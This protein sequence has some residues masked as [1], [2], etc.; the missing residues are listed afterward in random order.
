MTLEEIFAKISTHMAKGLLI[1]SQMA[2]LYGFLNLRG[3]QRCQ[4]YHY[5][6]ETK[7]YRC[8]QNFFLMYCNKLI[9]EEVVEQPN[10]IP[11]NWYKYPKMEVDIN[12]KRSAVKDLMKKWVEWEKETKVLLELSYKQL[13]ELGEINCAFKIGYFIEDVSKELADAQEQQISLE[14]IGYDIVYMTDWQTDLYK[15]YCKKIKEIH[16]GD[17]DD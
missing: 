4:E 14:S 15:Q 17:E 9:Q 13:Y 12:N 8:L 2:S 3:Y 10:I 5:Y 7:N 1:H 11:S 16:K 6:E